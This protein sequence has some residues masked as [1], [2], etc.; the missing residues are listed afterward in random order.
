MQAAGS[1]PN[2]AAAGFMGMNM[3]MNAAG[4]FVGQA[5]QANLQQMQQN[6]QAAGAGMQQA[7][8]R[9]AWTCSCGAVNNGNFCSQCGRPAPSAGT[10]TCSCGAVNNG[11]FCSQCGKPRA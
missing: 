5:S 2:G 10:W 4:G 1:N 6:A 11:N 8:Q 9:S 3:G 7:P